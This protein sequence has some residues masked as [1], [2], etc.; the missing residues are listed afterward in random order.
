MKVP[1]TQTSDFTKLTSSLDKAKTSMTPYV[2]PKF[3]LL[4]L[5]NVL[6]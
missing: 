2:K 4:K 6:G 3:D 5:R 1:A